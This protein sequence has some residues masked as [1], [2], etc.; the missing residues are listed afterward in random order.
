MRPALLATLLAI[1]C[2]SDD[3]PPP[4]ADST[5]IM[6]PDPAPVGATDDGATAGE[7]PDADCPDHYVGHE[8]ATNPWPLEVLPI[9]AILG[10]GVAATAAEPA[11]DRLA[12][13]SAAPS[14]F[15]ALQTQCPGYLVVE[16]RRLGALVPDLVLY[17]GT[18]QPVK[19]LMGTWER[20]VLKP[21]HRHVEAGSH[22]LEVRHSGGDPQAYSLTVLL[23]PDSMC[24]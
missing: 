22:V 11:G 19:E 15:F 16:L 13:C 8:Q 12:V 21:L 7:A 9:Q 5:G 10:D 3:A 20:F 24:D 4:S 14:D 6:V 17:D 18:G 1:G 2:G 23:L